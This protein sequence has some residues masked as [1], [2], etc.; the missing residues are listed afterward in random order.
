[1]LKDSVIRLFESKALVGENNIRAIGYI[2]EN[3]RKN[4]IARPLFPSGLVEGL[5]T[6]ILILGNSILSSL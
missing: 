5:I 4:E 1:M 3:M 2:D 6:E